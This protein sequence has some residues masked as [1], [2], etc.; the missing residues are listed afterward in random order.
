MSAQYLI[1]L[2]LMSGVGPAMSAREAPTTPQAG[3]END[4]K[5]LCIFNEDIARE[6]TCTQYHRTIEPRASRGQR[7]TEF[8]WMWKAH[9]GQEVRYTSRVGSLGISEFTIGAL[10]DGSSNLSGHA[11]DHAVSYSPS[12][13]ELVIGV[14][15]EGYQFS[16]KGCCT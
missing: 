3:W 7:W 14:P 9:N 15:G 11:S 5:R 12:R 16:V 4:G 13:K 6:I 8:R 2:L 1:A 10:F